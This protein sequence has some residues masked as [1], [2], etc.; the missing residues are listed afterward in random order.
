MIEALLKLMEAKGYL[1]ALEERDD[2]EY[3]DIEF[4]SSKIDKAIAYLSE[5][6]Q[7]GTRHTENNQQ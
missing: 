2:I 4:I 7:D 1:Q 6:G 3:Q 5:E